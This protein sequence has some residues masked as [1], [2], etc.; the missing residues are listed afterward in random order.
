MLYL[1]M[2]EVGGYNFYFILLY[3]IYFT[4]GKQKT[5]VEKPWCKK[6]GYQI[7]RNVKKY[8][9]GECMREYRNCTFKQVS[10]IIR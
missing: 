8:T 4:T 1:T 5:N 7:S 2:S 9:L 10:V 6:N 3:F